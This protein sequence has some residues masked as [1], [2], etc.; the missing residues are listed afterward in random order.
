MEHAT[1]VELIRTLFEYMDTKST[2]MANDV[3]RNNVTDYTSKAQ[4]ERERA[5]LFQHHPLLKLRLAGVIR[6]VVPVYVLAK[7][8]KSLRARSMRFSFCLGV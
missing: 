4:L 7:N 3:Y 1:Q 8:E 6:H 5:L 2:A